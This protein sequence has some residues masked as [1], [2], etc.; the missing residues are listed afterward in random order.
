MGKYLF[1]H[2]NRNQEKFLLY[3]NEINADVLPNRC[4]GELYELPI[5]M[6]VVDVA[7]SAAVLDATKQG[8]LAALEA[9]PPTSLIG[10][11]SPVIGA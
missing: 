9:L 4:Q 7:C 3:K 10:K 11:V 1:L 2:S 5:Y 8:I 6:F